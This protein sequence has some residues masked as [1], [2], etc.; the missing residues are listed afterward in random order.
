MKA[1]HA[2]AAGVTQRMLSLSQNAFDCVNNGLSL[3]V[4]LD[5]NQATDTEMIQ[6]LCDQLFLV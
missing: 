3:A 6:V 5:V 1:R 2:L 4:D